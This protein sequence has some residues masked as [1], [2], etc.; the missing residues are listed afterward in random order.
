[1]NIL[2]DSIKN[3]SSNLKN[4]S[5]RMTGCNYTVD[6]DIV[7]FKF[8]NNFDF[9]IENL[10]ILFPKSTIEGN[11]EISS[12]EKFYNE[13][14]HAFLYGPNELDNE[15]VEKQSEILNEWKDEFYK[16]LNNFIKTPPKSIYKHLPASDSWFD[17][18][19]MWGFCYILLW[20]NEGIVIAGQA[21]D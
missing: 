7:T 1:M 8:S 4:L 16:T 3:M 14:N 12:L 6:F 11:F 18:Y 5:E 19:I 10:K 9:K 15:S 17:F 13:I 21:W 2:N 20:E